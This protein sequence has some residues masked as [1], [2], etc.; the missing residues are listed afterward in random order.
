MNSS[1]PQAQD[2]KFCSNSGTV[3]G[4]PSCG[5]KRGSVA[6]LKRKRES[7]AA[8]RLQIIQQKE[9]RAQPTVQPK[10]IVQSGPVDYGLAPLTF[11]CLAAAA[12]FVF[13]HITHSLLGF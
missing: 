9:N 3:T 11:L 6:Q 2:C 8:K 7:D 5:L 13:A 4:C 1:G 12:Y 10:P